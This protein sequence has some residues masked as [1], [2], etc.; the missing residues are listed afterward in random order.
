MSAPQFIARRFM[1]RA[2]EQGTFSPLTLFA[3]LAIGVGVAA[4]S[5]LLSVMY[6]FE[7]ALKERLLNAYPHLIIRNKAGG[8][9][10]NSLEWT[11]RIRSVENVARVFPFVETEEIVQ[12][13]HR[14]I[15]AVIRGIPSTELGG[16]LQAQLTEGS[17]PS[18]Q[19]E[20]GEVVLGNELAERL[21]LSVGE[22]VRIISPIATT[23]PMGLMP[24]SQS[25]RVSGIFSSGHYDFDHQYLFLVLEDAQ[26]LMKI[27]NAVSGWHVYGARLDQSE[28]I[29]VR[30]TQMLPPEW[31]AQSWSVFN[32]ALF[33]ALKLEQYA[34]FLIL[35]FAILIAVL[36]IVITLMM[37]VTHK[38]RN[39]GILMAMG[40]SGDHIR[41]LFIWQGIY[42]GGVGLWGG[43]M[44]TAIFFIHL[45][46]FS[47]YQ[48]PEI[49]YDRSIPIEIRPVA[50]GLIFGIATLLIFLSTLLPAMRAA[51]LDPIEAIRE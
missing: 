49:Y 6:G 48:L 17:L 9:I 4:M 23:G 25:F 37:N 14:T 31:E 29:G 47:S 18:L 26:D 13:E 11:A 36:N 41:R 44:L 15:G 3:W 38:R 40:A 8:P 50:L 30:L 7:A 1:W 22:S 5:C 12:S 46:Y 27:G 10:P 32:S 21:S 35:S 51:R 34:M 42:L 45:K 19:S 28:T 24:R 2:T 16:T 20:I 39:I 43:A 33:H